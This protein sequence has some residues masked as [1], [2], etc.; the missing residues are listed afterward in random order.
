MVKSLVFIATVAL[1]GTS[2]TGMCQEN[3]YCGDAEPHLL[4]ST[5]NLTEGS[6]IGSSL[7][8]SNEKRSRVAL[9]Y[10]LNK[11]SKIDF[12]C[13]V[14]FNLF[15]DVQYATR[16][17]HKNG[18][19]YKGMDVW[20]G[21][22][23]DS[24]FDHW[25]H[26]INTVVAVNHQTGK[27]V[28]NIQ[29]D[30]G[31]YQILPTGN[32]D[33]YRIRDLKIE[34]IA[35]Y[36]VKEGHAILPEEKAYSRT[37]CGSD[38]LNETDENGNY[39]IDVFVG[40]SDAAAA[41]VGDINAHALS[42]IQAVNNGLT[43]SLVET[44]Y[45][46][47]VGTGTTVN[48]PG[49]VTS[50]L[51]DCY[52]WF[53]SEIEVLAP[54]IVGV[55]QV[56]TGAPGEA[57]GWAN[58]GGFSNVI[59]VN[60]P[61]AFRHEVGHNA[62]GGH[63]PGGNGLFPYA[64]GYDNGNWRTHMCGNDVNY[65]S[66]PD[67]LDNQG[68]PIGN[69][70]VADMART[71]TERAYIMAQKGLHRIEYYSGDNCVNQICIPQHSGSQ[72][73]L[74]KRVVFNTIDNNQSNQGWN[75]PSIIGYSD[76]TNVT[77]EIH[78]NSTYAI[79]ITPNFSFSDSKVGVWIDWDNNGLLSI[80]ERVANF[81]GVGPWSQSIT[82][83]SNTYLGEVR[84]RIRLQYGPAYSPDPCNHS[85]YTS[86]ETE[87]YTVLVS[88]ALPVTLI[89]FRGEKTKGGN[90]LRW[91]TAEE[92]NAS[93]FDV[94]HS[95]TATSFDKIG[96]MQAQGNNSD[97]SFLDQQNDEGNH[98]YRLKM[99]DSDGS[100]QYSKIISVATKNQTFPLALFPNPSNGLLTIQMNK[101][102]GES[103]QIEIFNV[104]SQKKFEIQN[105]TIN[106]NNEIEID[107]SPLPPGA[108]N[109]VFRVSGDWIGH[110]QLM[111]MR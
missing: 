21:R 38:C 11:E 5:H 80:A 14:I 47:L 77:T 24:R 25:G 75:C 103:V 59:S 83:P 40:Y 105:I 106:G 108:Y 19:H 51:T 34:S 109:C 50:V 12:S 97:Y 6:E 66:N 88:L 87:D 96:Q 52:A 1:I 3:N 45:L 99:V 73:E 53:A 102:I 8:V 91:K 69:P 32:K 16:L 100:F 49:V 89:D 58:V 72:N 22:V 28:A 70:D 10:P 57:G 33:E 64:H 62:G 111:R 92:M 67:I 71:W 9:F 61:D 23:E 76:Y 7:L 42:L 79:T 46:R 44:T 82:V 15:E 60:L 20:V 81:T 30:R 95:A 86:G 27:I 54:D 74:I 13:Q 31:S 48:N 94:E 55:I 101:E 84:L 37:V 104:F 63:C 93:H 110:G 43:N 39:V 85:G 36:P 29:T 2:S 107:I 98:F 78:Q 90:L 26:Y 68:N 18:V 35:C 17:T 4:F 41:I 65:Y 56:P